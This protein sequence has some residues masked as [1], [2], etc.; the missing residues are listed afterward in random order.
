MMKTNNKAFAIFFKIILC[1]LFIC[2]PFLSI[3]FEIRWSFWNVAAFVLI[4][5]ILPFSAIFICLKAKKWG[6]WCI[7]IYTVLLALLLALVYCNGLFFINHDFE[8]YLKEETSFSK[9]AATVMPSRSTLENAQVLFFEHTAAAIG[10]FEMYKISV[11]YEESI[12][13]TES[14]KLLT[15]YEANSTKI[16]DHNFYFDGTKYLCYTFIEDHTVYA[17]AYSS[18]EETLTISYIFFK[19]EVC[20]PSMSAGDALYCVYGDDRIFR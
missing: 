1:V 19:H 14:Q 9:N 8:T 15:Q 16:P 5:G 10:D 17:M 4:F 20:L 18:C 6:R 11:K 7:S 2:L 12:F 13:N 3:T